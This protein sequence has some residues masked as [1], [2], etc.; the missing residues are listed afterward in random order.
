MKV[1]KLRELLNDYDVNDDAEVLFCYN[2]QDL[3]D[4]TEINKVFTVKQI[5]GEENWFILCG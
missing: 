2:E 5:D 4:N 3:M 1:W